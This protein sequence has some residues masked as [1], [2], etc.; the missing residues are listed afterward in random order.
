[1]KSLFSEIIHEAK[2]DRCFSPDH[3]LQIEKDYDAIVQTA[4]EEYK[5]HPPNK[6]FP[7][8][9]SSHT[10]RQAFRTRRSR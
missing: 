8:G 4:R 3:I 10:S 9:Y 2:Q 7:G 1:M 5:K 6:Y